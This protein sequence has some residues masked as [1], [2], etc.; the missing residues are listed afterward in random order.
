MRTKLP[1]IVKPQYVSEF[2]IAKAARAENNC[3]LYLLARRLSTTKRQLERKCTSM[4]ILQT[5]ERTCLD[6]VEVKRMWRACG[7]PKSRCP[8]H[9]RQRP[10]EL[11]GAEGTASTSNAPGQHAGDCALPGAPRCRQPAGGCGR[12]RDGGWRPSRP[13]HHRE[14]LVPRRASSRSGF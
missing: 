12:L 6:N 7:A 10:D 13:G 1:S 4:Y 2:V 14:C 11:H 3:P 8:K 9:C 5:F